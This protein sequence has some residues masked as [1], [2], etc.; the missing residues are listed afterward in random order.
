MN[1]KTILLTG[2]ILFSLLLSACSSV[3]A[4][5]SD[6]PEQRS[7]SVTGTGKTYI[8]PD[9]AYIMIGVHTEGPDAA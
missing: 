6:V 8:S 4:A 2:L 9:I 1:K 3:A 5:Q 7:L